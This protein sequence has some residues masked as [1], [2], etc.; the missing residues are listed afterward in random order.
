M[1]AIFALLSLV[2]LSCITAFHR[3]LLSGRK[4][5]S[6]HIVLHSQTFVE[7][8]NPLLEISKLPKFRE[9]E[10]VHVKPAV[11][12]NIKELK[13][14]FKNFENVLLNPT[15]GEAWGK[16][17]IEYDYESVID[18]LEAMSAPLGYS[19]GIVGHLMGVKNS[20]ELR[21][22]HD[23][24][25]SQVIEVY[26][27][28]G[29]SEPLYKALTSIE[30]R[31]SVW[32]NL[33]EGQQ[34]VIKSSIRQM[35]NSGV[36]LDDTIRS[37]F[38][39]LQQE[40]AELSTKFSN[41]VLDSTKAFK[42][43][44]T[45]KEEV[46]G[47]PLSA[48]NLAAQQAIQAGETSATAESGPWIITLDMPSYLPAMQH[49]KNR[50]LRESLYRAYV[51]R[52]S[53]GETDNAPIIKRILQIKKEMANILGFSSHAERSLNSK[54]ADSVESVME[55]T[56]MLLTKSMP[57]A[58]ND[59]TTLKKFAESQ[60]FEEELALWDITYYSE[61]LR[62]VEYEFK[63]EELRPYFSLPNVLDGLFS[64]AN[65]LFGITIIAA[66]GK[67]HVWHPDV[68]FFEIYDS[69]S[70]EYLASFFLDPYSR[71]GV[72]RGGAWMDVCQGKSKVLNKK[73]V[74]YLTCNGSPAIGDTPSLM[75]FRE[76]ITLFHE[77]GHGLQHMLTTVEYAD[78]AGINNVEWDAVELPSQFMENW[79]YDKKTIFNIAR[80]Y[81][82]G[83]VLPEA[84]FAKILAAKNFQAGLGML[85]QLFFGAMDLDIH[86][87]NFDPYSDVSVFDV[88][89][90]L[91]KK[92]TVIPP[93]AEDKFL[94]AFGHIFAGGYSAG[95]YSY[96]WAEVMSA[97]AFGAFE[98]V[99]MENEE[100]IQT[101]GR[102]F[103]DTVLSMGGS[104]APMEVFKLF[105]G[106]EPKP[107]ALLRHSGLI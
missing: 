11:E 64:L 58:E 8:E 39:K 51:T 92:Y 84:L 14:N 66:D 27:M 100:E 73:P 87:Q 56:E 29:Q 75:T 10:P 22:A 77:M 42:L 20:D 12:N 38:N 96:K 63:E 21:A 60:G 45:T 82:T 107:D 34:R 30:K 57:A 26:Q 5:L 4:V 23:E 36:G 17:R 88:Q 65:R 54:M 76:V 9:I 48:L 52:A 13:S 46:S 93:L 2:I 97:D 1:L 83:E 104:K 18:Q 35:K 16:K 62:E 24:M 43:K 6:T 106:R 33:D 50:S 99:G 91:A 105:R 31:K 70:K 59:M 94:C 79:C 49:L 85:R 68:R 69:K 86:S 98:E 44:L 78:A 15:S 81:Q 47:L 7:E 95:Y 53:T 25:Q 32:S 103:R 89:N 74:A 101:V 80:H 72:K 67:E 28:L 102:R 55:L 37:T 3:N 90:T 41:N 71:P 19:W 40:V 61:R